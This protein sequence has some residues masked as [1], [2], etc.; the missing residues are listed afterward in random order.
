[1]LRSVD[2][3]EGLVAAAEA[4]RRPAPPPP[5]WTWEDA[6]AATWEVYAQAAAA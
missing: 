3:V 1:V 5:A 6:A 2:D 4:A